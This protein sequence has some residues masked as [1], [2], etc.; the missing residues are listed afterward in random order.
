[1]R[2]DC[3]PLSRARQRAVER[4]DVRIT[5]GEERR[6]CLA[7]MRACLIAGRP[8][9]EAPLAEQLCAK[10]DRSTSVRLNTST[11]RIAS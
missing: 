11:G 4:E 2:A 9:P 1:M 6:F 7:V 10:A 5:R 8:T 3:S